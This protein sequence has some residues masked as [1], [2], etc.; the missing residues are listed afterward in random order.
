MRMANKCVAFGQGNMVYHVSYIHASWLVW[1]VKTVGDINCFEILVYKY[2]HDL[3]NITGCSM[4]LLCTTIM[5]QQ[6]TSQGMFN[7]R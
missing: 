6:T 3:W 5:H 4:T 2:I 1:W 7:Q